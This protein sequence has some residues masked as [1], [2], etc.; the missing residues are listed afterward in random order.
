MAD[1]PYFFPGAPSFGAAFDIPF[2]VENRSFFFE[3]SNLKI[4][5]RFQGQAEG[6]GGSKIIF[7][8]NVTILAQGSNRL[9]PL[10]HGSYVCPVRS[11]AVID[12]K[13]VAE[14]FYSAQISFISEYNTRLFGWRRSRDEDGPFTL[15]T[16][17]TPQRWVKGIPLK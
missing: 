6:P 2:D 14:L 3:F 16:T 10:S 7:G 15:I 17:T 12:G 5:C 13:N 1:C 11:V 4:S 8:P 9:Q